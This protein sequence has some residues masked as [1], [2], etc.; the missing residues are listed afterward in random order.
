[1]CIFYRIFSEPNTSKSAFQPT[2]LVFLLFQ[3]LRFLPL[4]VLT[5]RLAVFRLCIPNTTQSL[6][7][8]SSTY[9]IFQANLTANAPASLPTYQPASHRTSCILPRHSQPSARTHTP[10]RGHWP[11][12]G[13]RSSCL[14]LPLMD[15]RR[16][17]NFSRNA[18]ITLKLLFISGQTRHD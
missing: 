15:R 11:M 9:N 3:D 5:N 18:P 7:F 13:M 10:S 12:R 6:F 17:L 14:S 16:G 1:M 4:R 2:H 8:Y